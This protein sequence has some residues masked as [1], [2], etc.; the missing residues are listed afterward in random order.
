VKEEGREEQRKEERKGIKMKI[1]RSSR[2][3][4]KYLEETKG[5]KH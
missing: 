5:K 3:K 2:K 4:L 1:H